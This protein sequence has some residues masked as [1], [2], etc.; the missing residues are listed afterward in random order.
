VEVNTYLV[1]LTMGRCPLSGK[2]IRKR[3]EIAANSI[4]DAIDNARDIYGGVFW[5]AY[6]T[7]ESQLRR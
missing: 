1:F 6:E 3:V 2:A 4:Y 7:V 5:L